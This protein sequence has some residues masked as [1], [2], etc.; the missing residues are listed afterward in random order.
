[1]TWYALQTLAVADLVPVLAL[2]V[3]TAGHLILV[4]L[5]LLLSHEKR[6]N[7]FDSSSKREE[8]H[9][10]NFLDTAPFHQHRQQ[11]EVRSSSKSFLMRTMENAV[12]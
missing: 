7:W 1:M 5:L 10:R 8:P 4:L 2:E 12:I 3:Q 9:P 11:G 6:Y